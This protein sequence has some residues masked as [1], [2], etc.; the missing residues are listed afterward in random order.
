MSSYESFSPTPSDLLTA[1]MRI[2]KQ[3]GNCSSVN[4]GSCPINSTLCGQ[5]HFTN[6]SKVKVLVTYFIAVYGEQ[7]AKELLTEELV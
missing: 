3:Q 6:E 4:C 1:A 7:R 5:K 2:I